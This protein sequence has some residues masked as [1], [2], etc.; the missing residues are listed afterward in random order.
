MQGKYQKE[1]VEV[2]NENNLSH[3][4]MGTASTTENRKLREY[5]ARILKIVAD[6]ADEANKQADNTNSPATTPA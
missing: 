6:V 2:L 4:L 5:I 1:Y 3:M